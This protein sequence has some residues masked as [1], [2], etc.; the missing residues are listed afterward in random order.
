MLSVLTAGGG[1]AV[2]GDIILLTDSKISG[3][4][5]TS[6]TV[7]D[8]TLLGSGA[9]VK[10]IA[11]ILKTSVTAK[12]KS[13]KLS[14]QLKVIADDADGA[15]GTRATDVDISFGRA[16]VYR[17]QAVFDSESTSTDAAAPTITL[18]SPTGTFLRGERF[19]GGTSG[20][21]GRIISATTPISYTLVNGVAATDFVTGETI[22]GAHSGATATAS[23]VTAGSKNITNLFTLDTGQRDNY[24][25]TS[26]LVRKPAASIP[27]GRLLVVYDYLEHGAGDVFTVDSYT[28][29]NGQMEYDDIPSYSSTRVDPDQPEP[30]GQF[31]LRDAYDFRPTVED[32]TGASATITDIDQI[33]GNSF[34]FE[35]RQFD[36]TGASTVDMLK[37]GSSIQSDFEYYLPKFATLFLTK[38]GDFKIIEGVSAES[39]VAPKDIDSALKL[40]TIFLPAYTFEPKELIIDRFKTQRFTMRDIGR[41]QDRLDNVEYYTA[42]SLLEKDAASFEVVDKDGL[43]RF[44]SGFVVDNFTGHRV[45]DALNKDYRVSI[46][47]DQQHMRPKCV[48]KNVGLEVTGLTK[49]AVGIKNNFTTGLAQTGDLITLDYTD[50]TIS[51]QPYATRVESIQPYLMAGFV[52]KVVLTPSGDEWFETELLLLLL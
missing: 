44:K 30:T 42:L 40:A 18:T 34:N 6:I 3:E 13:T 37:P 38:D 23:V 39:P 2:Q 36:G 43:N 24:Y 1:S 29:L 15:Y 25:D 45:G 21:V 50:E 12:T 46:D 19:T 41:L 52:G 47:Q 7:T 22:T 16:D 49:S 9:K 48:L 27:L 26:R 51:R 5:S 11:T 14:K 35:N 20:A 28:S 8:S 32:I 17:L 33:T 4:G 31:D 10:L